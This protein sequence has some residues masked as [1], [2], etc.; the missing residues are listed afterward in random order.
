MAFTRISAALLLATSLCAQVVPSD[1]TTHYLDVDSGLVQNN[2]TSPASVG[3][4]QVVWSTVVTVPKASWLRL[5]YAGVLLSGS[6]DRGSDGSFLRITSLQD[7]AV[8]TQHLRHVGEWQDTSAYFNGDSVMVELLA[9]AGT[10]DNRLVLKAAQVGPEKVGDPDSICGA[11]DDRVLSNDPRV[12]RNQPTGCTSWMINDCNHCFLTAGHCAGSGL[13]VVQFNVPLSSSTGSLNQPP[14]SDQYAVDTASLQSNGGQGV[15]DDW[16]YF[17][18]FDNSTTGLSPYAAQGNQAFD[19]V[20][21]PQVSGQNIRITGNGSTSAPVS[22]TWYLVQK[23]HS[24]PYFSLTGTAV[25]YTTDTTGGNSGSPVIL[26]GTNQAIGIHT[27]GGCTSTGGS[28]AGT[29][30]NHTALQAALASPQGVCDCPSVE[31]AFPNGLPSLIDPNGTTTLRVNT[32]GPVAVQPATFR[33]NYSTGGAYQQVIPTVVNST[34]F[35]V[36]FPSMSCGETAT[37]FFNATGVDNNQ[38]TS[39]SSAPAS[40]YSCPVAQQLITVRNYD[41]NTQP[42]GWSVVNTALTTGAW[43]RGNP[44]DPRG[45]SQ[46]FD[47]SGQCYVTGNS[48]NEDV[49]GGPTE[50]ITET[51]DLSGASAPQVS[52]AIWY[53]TSGSNPMTISASNN[54]GATWT[55]VETLT[56]TTGWETR[57]VDVASVFA[58]P[59][60]FAM[61]FSATDNPNQWITEAALDAFRID[62]VDCAGSAI[63]TK[64]GAGCPGSVTAP[65][66]CPELNPNG[67]ALTL[68]L[69]DNEYTYRVVNTGALTVNGF[70]IWGASI[71][72]NQTVAARIYSDVN[73]VPSATPVASTTMTIGAAQQFYTATFSSPV[74]VNG[75]FYV[76]YETIA[77]NVYVCTLAAGASGVGFYRDPVN[78]PAAWTQSGLVT[79]PSYRVNCA[80]AASLT[81]TLGSS[82]LPQLGGSYTVTLA[83][84]APSTFAVLASGLSNTTWSGGTLPVALPGAPGCSLLVDPAVLSARPT[85]NANVAF[86]VPNN[87]ALV[88]TELFHQWCVLDAVNPAG[89]VVSDAGRA[90]VGN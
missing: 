40:A 22:P 23:T 20:T 80:G 62:D 63:F 67:G 25:R 70:D 59:G 36:T 11:N 8:Q 5:E 79:A 78:G 74:T 90:R 55:T 38:Y 88:G 28:N 58:N 51:I 81:P 33:L 75:N 68:D 82:G 54:G 21:P 87:G 66:S 14:P 65:V 69:R 56:G 42:A 48:A 53:D 83:D 6:R 46:D 17:G 16:A 9:H 13:Q 45:P 41:F 30:A 50:L 32:T 12:A 7:G 37:F 24:G 39:P 19:L 71:G 61:R 86:N 15:G 1:H 77:Q 44:I 52:F 31:F 26:D 72:G 18:V 85:G 84:E 76:G 49:D 35:D 34:T 73:G 47:G 2:S 89:L 57:T 43:V 60:Q 3:I 27:H 64:F 10:G 4:P 29:G